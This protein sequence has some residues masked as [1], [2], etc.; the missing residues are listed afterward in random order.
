MQI[1]ISAVHNIFLE[2]NLKIFQIINIYLWLAP[3]IIRGKNLTSFTTEIQ[4]KS[5]NRVLSTPSIYRRLGKHQ[6]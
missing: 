1:L 6:E 2:E 4:P 3:N 5:K